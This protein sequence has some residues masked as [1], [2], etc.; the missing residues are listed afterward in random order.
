[1]RLRGPGRRSRR[2]TPL[3]FD[4]SLP[5]NP[6]KT[7]TLCFRP[8][9]ACLI[10]CCLIQHRA[11]PVAGFGGSNPTNRGTPEG[12]WRAPPS[13]SGTPGAD[14]PQGASI[15]NAYP[16]DRSRHKSAS[17]RQLRPKGVRR[18]LVC[19]KK[20]DGNSLKNPRNRTRALPPK[21]MSR[22]SSRAQFPLK[23]GTYNPFQGGIRLNPSRSDA[24][25]AL[26]LFTVYYIFYI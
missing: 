11:Q 17:G 7:I 23:I 4:P 21:A 12:A 3:A 9:K 19:T 16:R 15:R 20:I 22:F 2:A 8:R 18:W 13:P 25:R 6:L 26:I 10:P 5:S 14:H 24:T 1:M